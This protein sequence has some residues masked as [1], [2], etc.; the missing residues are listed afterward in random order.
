[1][2]RPIWAVSAISFVN[3][4]DDEAN[5]TGLQSA[6]YLAYLDFTPDETVRLGMTVTVYLQ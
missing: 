5:A 1:M 2:I 4:E 6:Q 3:R